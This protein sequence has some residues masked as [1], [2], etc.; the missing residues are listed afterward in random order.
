MPNI[1]ICQ[2]NSKYIHSSL[3]AWYILSGIREYS[4]NAF[5][6]SVVEGTV[7]EDFLKIVNRITDK[8]PD[9]VGFSCYI[10]NI[11]TVIKAAK[12][13]KRIMP[14]VK[15]IFGGPEVSYSYDKVLNKGFCDYV[16][17][18]AGE[19]SF[20]ELCDAITNNSELNKINGIA[21]VRDNKI[22]ST[23]AKTNEEIPNPYVPEYFKTLNGRIA[24]L[25]TSRGCPFSC[26]FCLSG[27]KSKM[28]FFDEERSKDDLLRLAQSGTL[29]IKLV[30]RTFNTD[31]KRS[32]RF[33]NF[34]SENY[35][36]KIPEGVRIHFEI[37]PALLDDEAFDAIA[38]LP[39]GAVQFEVGLQSF[40]ID[41]LKAIGRDS[42]IKRAYENTK[43]LISL[44]NT[45]VHTDLIAGLPFEN[46]KSFGESF[47]KAYELGANMLQLGFLKILSGSPMGDVSY[48]HKCK[49]S[50]KPPYEVVRTEFLNK[51]EFKRLHK[52]EDLHERINNSG[53]FKRTFEY[54]LRQTKLAPFAL[55]EKVSDNITYEAHASLD[56]FTKAFLD[57]LEKLG[58]KNRRELY[59]IA[60]IDRITTNREGR[61]PEFLK[62]NR[63]YTSSFKKYLNKTVPE[64]FAPGIKSSV[65]YLESQKCGVYVRYDTKPDAI[66]GA[67]VENYLKI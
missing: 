9:I 44:G 50:E 42:D 21:F 10:W 12:E 26:A 52:I 6:A 35:G 24:Y 14:Q 37:S 4:K 61:I 25:E 63:E 34:I 17:I 23:P 39:Y 60:I 31:K 29:T 8:S 2:I 65:M 7:N 32:V 67:Y 30:D 15:I 11:E 38:K 3:A 46:Y 1:V 40:N 47:N 41:T 5:S 62:G 27:H 49:F 22:V 13:L 64:L 45:H 43:R 58:V 53:R 16:V 56:F 36:T 55:L 48:P 59:D 57:T 20:Q 33:W 66:S 51:T 19:H 28:Q 18:G 54:A